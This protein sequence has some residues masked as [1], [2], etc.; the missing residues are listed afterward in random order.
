MEQNLNFVGWH[1]DGERQLV[2]LE[3]KKNLQLH[4]FRKFKP[5]SFWRDYEKVNYG[6]W[7]I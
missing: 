1:L 4:E 7:I 3:K 5:I 6:N 2:S